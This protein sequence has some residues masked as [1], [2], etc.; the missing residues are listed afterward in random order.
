ME[1]FYSR[2]MLPTAIYTPCSKA[3]YTLPLLLCYWLENILRLDVFSAVGMFSSCCL[4]QDCTFPTPFL[5]EEGDSWT[6]T[7]VWLSICCAAQWEAAIR[8]GYFSWSHIKSGDHS[9]EARDKAEA[10]DTP[11]TGT[12][13]AVCHFGAWWAAWWYLCLLLEGMTVFAG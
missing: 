2:Q 13:D 7:S 4:M 11:L 1:D 9:C 5:K 10:L 3:I 8:M 12:V 6:V